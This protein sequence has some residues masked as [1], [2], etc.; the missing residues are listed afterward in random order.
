MRLLG[1]KKYEV[2]TVVHAE[3]GKV[4]KGH[5]L[6]RTNFIGTDSVVQNN[7]GLK[8]SPGRYNFEVPLCAVFR[9]ILVNEQTCTAIV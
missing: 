7:Q 8:S 1:T 6:S 2:N 5:I 4:S 9:N 3:K